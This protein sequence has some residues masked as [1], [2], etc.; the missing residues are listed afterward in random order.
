MFLLDKHIEQIR[1]MIVCTA[2]VALKED[3]Y[4]VCVSAVQNNEILYAL[5]NQLETFAQQYQTAIKTCQSCGIFFN[6][7]FFLHVFHFKWVLCE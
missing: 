7:V 3:L 6:V 1:D 2:N 5:V 4:K